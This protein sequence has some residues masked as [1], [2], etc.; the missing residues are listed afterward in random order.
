MVGQ[1][2]WRAN[3]KAFRS[4]LKSR[5]FILS[6][7]PWF[8]ERIRL[9]L[10]WKPRRRF[11]KKR[12][13]NRL[14]V[15]PVYLATSQISPLRL[16]ALFRKQHRPICKKFSKPKKCVKL[17][18]G[19]RHPSMRNGKR[20]HATRVIARKTRQLSQGKSFFLILCGR[21]IAAVT[22]QLLAKN[23]YGR[24][25]RSLI[26]LLIGKVKIQKNDAK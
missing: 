13:V 22:V 17:T 19:D 4:S 3:G 26:L 23:F 5:G 9:L 18:A 14:G 2:H 21:A 1:V 8:D 12:S 16:F 6:I 24:K 11:T 15:Y 7:G 20:A 10:I 25:D